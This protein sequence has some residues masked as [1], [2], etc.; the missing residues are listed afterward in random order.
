LAAGNA[1]VW[2]LILSVGNKQN[3]VGLFGH[4]LCWSLLAY[5]ACYTMYDAYVSVTLREDKSIIN[6]G[7]SAKAM[8]VAIGTSITAQTGLLLV[9][10]I[11]NFA[12][13]E[14]TAPTYYYLW[15]WM[16]SLVLYMSSTALIT[17]MFFIVFGPDRADMMNKTRPVDCMVSADTDPGRLMLSEE[18]NHA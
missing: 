12:Y 17:I 3:L 6:N 14:E 18:I 5:Y 15:A 7:F 8:K 11:F 1:I 4:Q 13:S 16:F 2:I 10:I 9:D